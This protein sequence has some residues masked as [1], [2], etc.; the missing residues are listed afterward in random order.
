MAFKVP[1]Q[2]FPQDAQDPRL[3]GSPSSSQLSPQLSLLTLAYLAY[4]A[5]FAYLGRQAYLAYLAYVSYFA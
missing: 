4:F 3:Q 2:R 1:S 5:Y